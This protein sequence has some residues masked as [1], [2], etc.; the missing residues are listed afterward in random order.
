[1]AVRA[2]LVANPNSTD[3]TV[4]GK[5]A[6]A[7]RVTPLNLDDAVLADWPG[8]GAAGCAVLRADVLD[9]SERKE[10]GFLLERYPN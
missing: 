6:V 5:V 3:V 8:W 4:N 7:E 9:T 10:I 1:M 2:C